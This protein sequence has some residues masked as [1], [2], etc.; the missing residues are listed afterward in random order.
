VP[1][2]AAVNRLRL[3]LSL[4]AVAAVLASA[5]CVTSAP[6]LGSSAPP[7]L[8]TASPSDA[9][10]PSASGQP[11]SAPPVSPAS[12]PAT[13]EA[14][15]AR[16]R[17]AWGPPN[18]SAI[19]TGTPP[20]TAPATGTATMLIVTNLGPITV[21]MDRS[22]TPCTVASFAYLA[23]SHFFDEGPCHRLTTAGAFLLQ[24]G[25]PTGTGDGGPAYTIPDEALP[26]AGSAAPPVNYPRGTVAMANY[27][28]PNSGGSQFFLVYQ[29]SPFPDSYTKFGT[30]S[31][32][33]AIL[34]DV[35]QAGVD[36]SSASPHDGAPEQPIKIY[37]V[38]V[39]TP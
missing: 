23:G 22:V 36:P 32:G 1:Y 6:H 2:S 21:K 12:T 29:D 28:R 31:G 19:Q 3:G 34:D 18:P 11:S 13:T 17:C 27:G 14:A 26:P 24:C 8:V 30:I 38:T 16:V 15:D 9:G 20:A 39:I 10:L 37:S 35:A 4:A 7:T 5:G 25:D 33:I